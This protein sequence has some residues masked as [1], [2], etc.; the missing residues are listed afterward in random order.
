[1]LFVLSKIVGFLIEPVS[2]IALL[3]GL[4][5]LAIVANR[6][7]T[8]FFLAIFAFL[9]ASIGGWTT[10][11]TMALA[12]LEDRFPRPARMPADVTGVIV[13]GGGFEGGV[14]G[15]RGQAELRDAGD[16]FVEAVALALAYPAAKIVVTGGQGALVSE[17]ETDAA[18]APGFFARFGIA[19]ERLILEGQSRNTQENAEFLRALIAPKPGETWL[20]VTSAFHMPRS[21]GLF[22]KAGIAVTP[23]PVDYR[24]AGLPRLRL[25]GGA[26]IANLTALTVAVRE[27]VGLA[28]YRALGRIDAAFPAP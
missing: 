3:A 18:L 7:R 19:P 2:V 14:S 12:V 27:W 16:R 28:S 4:A 1:M 5:A 22:R 9:V 15:V 26:P 25:V 11:G 20:L 13:L 6:R 24:T 21:V 10:A 17:G 23:W 8:A